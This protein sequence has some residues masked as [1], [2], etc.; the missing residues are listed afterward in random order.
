MILVTGATGFIGGQLVL[1]LLA[2]GRRVRVLARRPDKVVSAFGRLAGRLDV[3][4]GD[5]GDANSLV[6]A[7]RGVEQIYHCASW[8]SYK[9]PAERVW[10]VNVGGT[11][12]LMEAACAAG[13]RRAVHMS[14]VAAGG[15]AVALP[16]GGWRGRTEEDP[17]EPLDDPYGQSKLEQERIVLGFVERGL[18]VVVVRPSAV[19]GPG[20]PDG[21]NMLLKMVRRGRLPFYLGGRA[22]PVNVVPVAHV[23]DGCIAAM[24][25]GRPGQIYNLVGPNVTHEQLFRIL[26]EVSGGRTPSFVMPTVVLR[27]AA[28]LVAGT[29]GLFRTPPVHPNDI[30]SWTSPWM[31]SAEKAR[32][33]LGVECSDLREAWEDTLIW[34]DAEGH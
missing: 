2:L 3:A 33:E 22:T 15:P 20:D 23:V 30:R 14:S 13:V 29:V 32:A 7:V 19:F 21:I 9:D 11:T 34:L 24:D 1:K 28:A 5:L 27:G 16:G 10:E 4:V 12:R 26:A 18:E 17:C 6:E 25:R 8:I 31:A